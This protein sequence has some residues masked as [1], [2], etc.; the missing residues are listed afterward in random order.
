M[1]HFL[2]GLVAIAPVFLVT[3]GWG[4]D[5]DTVPAS[6]PGPGTPYPEMPYTVALT[7]PT[8]VNGVQMPLMFSSDD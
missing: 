1:K 2:F 5:G 8:P 3:V 7:P 4:Q 6:A